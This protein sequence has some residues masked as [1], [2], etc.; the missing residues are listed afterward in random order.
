MLPLSAK[1]NISQFIE[2]FCLHAVT[3]LM[4]YLKGYSALILIL[5]SKT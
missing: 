4:K 5:F 3:T 2:L 1:E